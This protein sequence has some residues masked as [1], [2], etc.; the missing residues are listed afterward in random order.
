VGEISKGHFADLIAVDG[1]PLSD[2]KTLENVQFVMKGGMV[3]KNGV[4]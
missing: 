1:N 4:K 3:V 2:V